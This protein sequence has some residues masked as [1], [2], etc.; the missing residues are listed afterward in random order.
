MDHAQSFSA[1]N[2]RLRPQIPIQ[3]VYTSLNR[4][5]E[6]KIKSPFV[7]S[8]FLAGP[9]P[10]ACESSP[11]DD[12]EG[13]DPT[14]NGDSCAG[15]SSNPIHI[16]ESNIHELIDDNRSLSS[17]EEEDHRRELPSEGSAPSSQAAASDSEGERPL[18]SDHVN[19][20]LPDLINSGKPLSRRRTL[21]HVSE[22]LKEVRR[23]VELSRRRSIR[24]K[25]QVDR[26]QE[27]S[28]RPGWSQH[29]ERVKEEVLSILGLLRPLTESGS[30]P[31][32]KTSHEEKHLDT[33]LKEL[34]NVARELAIRHTKQFKSGRG[35]GAEESTI[36]QQALRD[37][38]EAMEK[39]KAMEA[40]LLRSKTELMVLNNQLLEAVQKR[41]ELA[42]E[43][44]TWK[45]DVQR[46]LHQQLQS[47]Q[48]A[49]QS[50]KKPAT[51]RIPRR[52]NK[53]PLQ[54]P[55]NFPL[56]R[57]VSPTTNPNQIFIPRA[58][59]LAAPNPSPSP[60]TPRRWM[61]KLRRKKN[62]PDGGQ[63]AAEQESEGRGADSGFKVVSLD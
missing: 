58:A 18:Q 15:L 8:T 13:E 61:D 32:P 11:G 53:E 63:S 5:E 10:K 41:L 34:Q 51:L 23:E 17:S 29:R 2:Q 35:K 42:L 27:S 33:S 19:K 22:T 52:T 57:A 37:R 12:S 48:Q 25:A 30:G 28:D 44:E 62:G 4:L 21:G 24:L 49:E 54:R 59:V 38:D 47:Q 14:S 7:R 9:E 39:K 60:S 46:I 50:Q 31:H 1:L 43:L 45:E 16:T 6:L 40:E 36:L 20:T 55:S 3:Q 26:L 56:S